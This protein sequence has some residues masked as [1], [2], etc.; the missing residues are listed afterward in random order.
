MIIANYLF[1]EYLEKGEKIKEVA[2]TT[3]LTIWRNLFRLA[4][5]SFFIPGILFLFFPQ[6]LIPILIWMIIGLFR[7]LYELYGWYYDVLLITNTGVLSVK[8]KTLFDV[9]TNRIEYHMIEGVSYTIKGFWQTIF[10]F[11]DIRVEKVGSGTP[12]ILKNAT[13]PAYIEKMILKN[14]EQYMMHRNL[15][16]HNTLK[17]LLTEMVIRHAKEK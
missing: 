8:S 6:L 13:N 4:A 3:I 15:Q 5:L 7:I 1:G 2:H 16:D 12:V 11:G 17:N 9:T 14:Q 10:N